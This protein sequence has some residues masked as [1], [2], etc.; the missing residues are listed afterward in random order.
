MQQHSVPLFP[1]MRD[2]FKQ[3]RIF[4]Q[5]CWFVFE[6]YK[7]A[8]LKQS[9]K[10]TRQR[11]LE[12][13]VVIKTWKDFLMTLEWADRDTLHIHFGAFGAKEPS[14]LIHF[15]VVS[16]FFSLHFLPFS[17]PL[18]MPPSFTFSPKACIDGLAHQWKCMDDCPLIDFCHIASQHWEA[19]HWR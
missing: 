9:S 19:V 7:S 17:P 14:L 16:P 13:L 8:L 5:I 11:L 15:L 6:K 1:N 18:A 2:M 12:Y 10:H 3:P 4:T